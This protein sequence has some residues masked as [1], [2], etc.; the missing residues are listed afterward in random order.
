[1]S[2]PKLHQS[3]EHVVWLAPDD[4]TDRPIIGA[5][6]GTRGT[7]IVEAG[8]SPAHLKLF[9]NEFAMLGLAPPR[10]LTA[11]HWHWDHVF[12]ASALDVP[13]MSHRETR[14]VVAHMATLDWSDEALD[15]RVREGS[16]IEFCRDMMK[17]EFS[18]TER[19]ALEI[20]VPDIAFATQVELDLGG[21]T[22]QIVNVGGD[23]GA[24]NSVVYVP[25]DKLLFAG[26]C[27]AENYYQ[28]PVHYTSEKLFPLLDRLLAFDV[29]LYLFGHN[30]EVVGREE[31][32]A[33]AERLKIIGK[34]VEHLGGQREAIMAE[35]LTLLASELSEDDLESM[36]SFIAGLA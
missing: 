28:P 27:T 35:L 3:T 8:N 16:E 12:G 10:F 36:S 20:R 22:C 5:V 25:E 13:F 18:E 11:T 1:M 17:K 24:D 33:Y 32:C 6:A 2:T 7:L 31:M 19:L 23:H 15:R 9:L 4:R 14:D 29:E 26:D 34:T 21:V 30:S